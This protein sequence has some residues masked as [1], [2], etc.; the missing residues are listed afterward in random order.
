MI[1]IGPGDT[2]ECVDAS[3]DRV[4][5][6]SVPL[7]EGALYVIEHLWHC[8]DQRDGFVGSSVD[9]VG[10]ARMPG[11]LAYGVQRFSPIRKP[12]ASD[13]SGE[14]VAARQLREAV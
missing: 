11:D 10:V 7:M 6:R 3:P 1:D 5:G 4:S 2:V 13:G 14:A 8:E 12:P 9:L